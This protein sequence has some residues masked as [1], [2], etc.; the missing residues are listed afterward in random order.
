[1][2]EME[3]QIQY[4]TSV[5][6]VRIAFWT[7]GEGTPLIHMPPI[8]VS[9][10]QR[11]WPFAPQRKFYEDLGP[12]IQLVRYDCRGSGLSDR[13]VFDYSVEAHI[14]DVLAV[15]DRL[16]LGRFA[17]MGYGHSGGVAI[18]IAARY[19]ELVSQ[20]VLWCAYPRGAEYGKVQRVR[21]F[22]KLM[23]Q[24]WE[25]WTR[26]ESLRL[27]EYEGGEMSEFFLDYVRDSLTKEGSKAAVAEL[28]K[29]DVTALMPKVRAPTLVLHRKGLSAITV[30]MA[31]EMAATIPH[32]RLM[33]FEGAWI[34]PFQGG[35]EE[36]AAAIREHLARPES[37]SATV[38]EAGPPLTRREIEVL[39][40][41]AAG[42]TSR[43][44]AS[45]FS[46][47]ARTVGRHITNIYAKIG[48]RTRADATAYAMR[49]GLVGS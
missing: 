13:E 14:A 15:A 1:M 41:I 4:V 9:N 43:E 35:G 30:E 28:R 31:R 42:R 34:S 49:R 20:L 5:D 38:K 7:R 21:T 48:A 2:L 22:E 16:G 18:E 3:P 25:F 10:I 24:D 46:L 39:R 26:A 17:L 47:S 11:E 36:I 6:G 45:E 23:D 19:P 33:L 32:A 44:I 37:A 8:P 29:V 40:L 12:N 27:S